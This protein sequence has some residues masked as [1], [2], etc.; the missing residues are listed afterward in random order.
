MNRESMTALMRNFV[1]GGG[2]AAID[3]THVLLLSEGVISSTF[4]HNSSVEHLLQVGVSYLVSL[5]RMMPSHFR[6]LAG[7]IG[8]VSNSEGE[9]RHRY[10]LCRQQGMLLP[11]ENRENFEGAGMHYVPPLGRTARSSTAAALKAA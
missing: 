1:S 10:R 5:N 11:R 8:S 4:C 6:M 9:R 3:Q 7:S 2:Y